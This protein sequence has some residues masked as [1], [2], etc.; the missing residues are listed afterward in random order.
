MVVSRGPTPLYGRSGR[1]KELR[2]RLRWRPRPGG[3]EHPRHLRSGGFCVLVV[4]AKGCGHPRRGCWHRVRAKGLARSV[5]PACPRALP[6][7]RSL[8]PFFLKPPF[9]WPA[10]LFARTEWRGGGQKSP[11]PD[12]L[13]AGW[14]A[15]RA[16]RAV[17]ACGANSCFFFFFKLFEGLC[18]VRR[19]RSNRSQNSC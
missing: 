7:R 9:L 16:A 3:G 10:F 13:P 12:P 14:Q 17:R 15:G 18:V 19:G 5:L 8:P 11:R 6:R 1:G 2:P 4:A